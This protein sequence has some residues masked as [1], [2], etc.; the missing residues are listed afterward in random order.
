MRNIC[1]AHTRKRGGLLEALT[2]RIT[3]I[4][5]HYGCGKTNL[6]VNLALHRR[7]AGREVALVDLDLVNPY[8]RS[9]DFAPLMARQGIEL[10]APIYAGTNLDLPALSGRLDS[11]LGADCDLIIDAG[12]DDAGAMVLGR[13]SAALGASGDCDLLYAVNFYRYLTR[14]PADCAAL[15]PEIERAA[16]RPATGLVNCSHLMGDTTAQCIAQ[17]DGD[18]RQAAALC[19][20]PLRFT[21]VLRPF[22]AETA[23]LLPGSTLFPLDLYVKKPWE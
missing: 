13:Y 20:L 1:V 12:G 8:F 7:A 22:V 16:R 11:L 6:A 2:H 14:T 18:A 9:A 23:R 15:L 5:G 21:A 4:T 10:V 19:G 3:I 17:T